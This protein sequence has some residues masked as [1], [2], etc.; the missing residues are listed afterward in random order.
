AKATLTRTQTKTGVIKGKVKYM[1]PEQALGRRLDHRS[2]LFSLGTVIYEMLTMKAPFVA[3]TEVELI[4]AVRDAKK[5]D[6]HE[7][8]PTVPVELSEI[9]NKLMSR[10]RSARYQSGAELAEALR[11][12]LD[13][14]HPGYRRSHFGRFMR[15]IFADDIEKELRILEDYVIRDANPE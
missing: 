2:D 15:R 14:F 8:E 1:S 12:F 11:D 9:V 10:S 13:R 4:F 3:P 7:V 6:A 5:I